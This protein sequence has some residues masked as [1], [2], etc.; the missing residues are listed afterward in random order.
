MSDASEE[1]LRERAERLGLHGLVLHFDEVQDAQWP[2]WLIHVEEEE[3]RRRSLERRLL[4]AKLGRFKPLT[5]FDWDW[6]EEIDRPVIREL[7]T[8]RFVAEQ[9]NVVWVGPNGVGKTML[10]KNLAYATLMAG[11]TVLF[12][13]ASAMLNALAAEDSASG[14]QRRLSRLCRPQALY[15]DE[16]G[17][18]SYG[19]RHA[20]LLFEVVTRRYAAGKP[21]VVT[22]NKAFAEWGEVFPNAACVVT[23]VDRL[24]HRSEVV[25][26]KGES[27]R[28][29]E[30]R[31]RAAQRA[32]ERGHKTKQ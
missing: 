2:P 16:V 12:T 30:A 1:D 19:N 6:P 8:L 7:F 32:K 15:I 25:S 5:E 4:N 23:L 29:K 18:L 3:R 21:V 10:A 28:L 26:I 22:T 31:E 14:L 13:T 27:Y 20:D 9:S 11:H 24:I 17:Y